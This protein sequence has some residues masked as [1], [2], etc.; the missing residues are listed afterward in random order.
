MSYPVGIAIDKN[1]AMAV[2]DY[3]NNRVQM[4]SP[5]GE[6]SFSIGSS[7]PGSGDDQMSD[8]NSIS[9]DSN[10]NLVISDTAN[11]RILVYG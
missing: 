8:P 9:I 10:G 2:T 4:W 1:G 5:E 6:F 7:V 11:N 3:G